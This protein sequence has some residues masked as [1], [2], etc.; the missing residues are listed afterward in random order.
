MKNLK[1]KYNIKRSIY[2][3]FK[4][5]RGS[6][7]ILVFIIGLVVLFA[8]ST[9]M[10]FL[11]RDIQFGKLDENKLQAL[12]LAEAGIS[13]MF[14]NIEKLNNGEI[15]NLP[16]SGYEVSVNIDSGTAGYYTVTHESYSTGEEYALHGY[17]I[18]S[19]GTDTTGIERS[20]QVKVLTLN[21][22]DFIYSEQSL[23]SAQNIAGNTLIYGP[24]L[25]NGE[26]DI[27]VGDAE[28]L[29][30]PLFVKNDIIIGGNASIGE[31]GTP[32]SLFLGGSIFDINSSKI[33][34][35]NPG[36]ENIYL[37]NFYNSVFNIYLPTIDNSYITHVVANYDVLEIN[38]DL[39]IGDGEIEVG[40]IPISAIGGE[41]ADYASYMD[42]DVNNYLNISKNIV[43]YG[44]VTIGESTGVT[45]TINYSGSGNLI[46]TGDIDVRSQLVPISYANFPQ[47]DLIAL[48]SLQDINLL[49]NGALGGTGYDNPN[50]ALMC[51][52]GS[53][54]TLENGVVL[55]GSSVSNSLIMSQNAAVYYEPGIGD[56][57]PDGVPEFNNI[58]FTLDWQEIGG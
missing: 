7:F 37:S 24:F 26:L 20:V 31:P 43:V 40:G 39:F 29:Q 48:V 27:T 54:I 1:R 56:F 6:T 10:S 9:M 33:N 42:F 17:K 32:I 5:T 38:G 4:S 18:V 45:Y 19:T 55:R 12:N 22:Y 36:D 25:V 28:F 14:L 52:S 53:L 2:K 50:A 58:L 15:T 21:I 51:I 47:D 49:L 23:S 8:V 41:L 13:N 34:P 46:S 44:N 35:L 30:G 3:I 11:Y 16:S 57:L